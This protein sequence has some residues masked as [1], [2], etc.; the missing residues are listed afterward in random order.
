MNRILSFKVRE[1]GRQGWGGIALITAVQLI[2]I[3]ALMVGGILGEGLSL[4]GVAFCA[5]IGSLILLVCACFVGI[6]SSVTGLSST[7]ICADAFGVWGA[8]LIPA[9]LITI[10]SA[11]WFGIQAAV[12]GVSFSV[13]TADVLG[14]S[15]PPWAATIF[16]GLVIGISTMYGY[17]VVKYFYNIIASVLFLILVYTVIRIVFFSEAGSAAALLAWR[18]AEPM[19]CV[20]GITLVV[21]VWAMGAFI[22]GDYCRYTKRPRDMVLGISA[23]LL[24]TLPA[25]FL[26]GAV[27]RIAAGSANITIILNSM[28]FPAISLIFLIFAAWVLNMVNAYSGGMAFSVM[29]SLGEKRLKA[30][31][32]LTGIAGTLLGAMGILS[33]FTDFLSLLSSLIPPLIG[34]LMGAQAVKV[35]KRGRKA[36]NDPVIPSNPIGGGGGGRALTLVSI[37]PG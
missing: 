36:G 5:V 18:P 20:T 33:R 25:M 3:P 15:I 23:G 30:G 10:T 16:W 19:S 34:V 37:F 35:L 13:L 12:C 9:L 27:S 11:G 24:F 32:A 1:Q 4:A 2:C 21:G 31:I 17:H 7:I 29:L 14:I 22:A 6:R 26:G 8:R 28:G